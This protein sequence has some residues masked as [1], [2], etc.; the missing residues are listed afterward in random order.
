[1]AQ[2]KIVGK[3]INV[4]LQSIGS[5]AD[6]LVKRENEQDSPLI[7]GQFVSVVTE[8]DAV[9]CFLGR[10]ESFR[11]DQEPDLQV[12]KALKHEGSHNVGIDKLYKDQSLYLNYRV[13]ILGVCEDD[14][15]KIKFYS[16]VRSMPSVLTLS[17]AIPSSN[18]MARLFQSAVGKTDD[19]RMAAFEIGTLKYG[20]FPEYTEKFYGGKNTVP[21]QFNAANL[22]RKRTAIFGK[23]GYGKSNTVKTVIGMMASQFPDCGQLIFDTNG[24]YALE[25]DQNDGFMDIFYDAG[26]RGKTVLYTARKIH[27]QKKEKFGSDSFKQLRFDV[28]ENISASLDIVVSNLAGATIPMYLQAWVNEAQGVENQ[29]ELFANVKNKGIVWGLWFKACKD[30]GLIPLN[31]Q[32]SMAQLQVSKKFLNEMVNLGS[33]DTEEGLEEETNEE[34]KSDT[35]DSLTPEQQKDLLQKLGILKTKDNKFISK[36]IHTMAMYGEWYYMELKKKEKKKKEGES[37]NSDGAAASS[38]KG[39]TELLNY[40]RRLYQLKAYNIG[41]L[42]ENERKGAKSVSLGDSVWQDLLAKKIVMIDLA[43]VPGNVAKSISEQIAANLLNKSSAMFGDTEQQDKFRNF[44]VLCFIEEAQNY[45]SPEQVKSGSGIYERL[46]KEGR[47]FHIGLVYVTQ[48]PSAIDE[49]ITSQTENIIAMHMSNGADTGMLNRIKDK[50]DDLTCKFLKDEAQQGLAYLYAEPHQ[51][52]V[53]PAQIHRFDKELI[54]RN[55]T[56]LRS[57]KK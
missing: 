55:L 9:K 44:D 32:T 46:A 6:I 34:E 2:H 49:T 41:Q 38:V 24:E 47:K 15:V 50:F 14:G 22:L 48:Q 33:E 52:F 19:G 36:N 25:N 54:L 51:P 17:I 42:P 53:L 45:L 20:T 21:V 43:S 11:P 40:Y 30:A 10:V 35:F 56:S 39:Y 29:T 7:V 27:E 13:R 5:F 3:V 4:D 12:K 28:F 1:M 57:K 31:E 26:I 16:N 23:S 37:D 8:E 18:F